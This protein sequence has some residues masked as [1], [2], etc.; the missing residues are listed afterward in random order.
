MIARYP[1]FAV[2]LDDPG[3]LVDIDTEADSMRCAAASPSRRRRPA[4][5][6]APL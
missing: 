6:V 2:E 3:V 5:A 1:A 4:P